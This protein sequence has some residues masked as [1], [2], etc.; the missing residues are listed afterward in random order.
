MIGSVLIY[1]MKIPDRDT[2]EIFNEQ[3]FWET[4]KEGVIYVNESRVLQVVVLT[5]IFINLFLVG[6][7]SM[8]L[9]LF[10]KN[11]LNGNAMDFSLLEAGVAVGMLIGSVIIGVL[12]LT[13]NRGKIA[14]I[15]LFVSGLAF[16]LLSFT[17]ERWVSIFMLI[18]FGACLSATNIPFT[19]AIQSMIEEKVLGRVMGLISLASMGLI[20]VSY[21]ITAFILSLGISIHYIMAGGAILVV[22]YTFFVYVNFQELRNVD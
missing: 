2:E 20:P 19:S 18:I 5:T 8:G 12:N 7:M 14:L 15:S 13:K 9:P 6:P 3:T 1:F 17:T 22:M 21:A 11:I 16:A 10:V 4:F